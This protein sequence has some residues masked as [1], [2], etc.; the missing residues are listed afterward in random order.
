MKPQVF[1]P[2]G[3]SI[4]FERTMLHAADILLG[5]AQLPRDVESTFKKPTWDV[6]AEYDM[7]IFDSAADFV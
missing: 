1:V 6:R 2:C 4:N 3:L 5:G 7:E